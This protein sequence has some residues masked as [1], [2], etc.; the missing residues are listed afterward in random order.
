MD[1]EMSPQGS[2]VEQQPPIPCN[3]AEAKFFGG[4]QNPSAGPTAQGVS[5]EKCGYVWTGSLF[6]NGIC[7][8]AQAQETEAVRWQSAARFH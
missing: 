1:R 6:L 4:D 7:A 8:Y 5:H 3:H 2:G